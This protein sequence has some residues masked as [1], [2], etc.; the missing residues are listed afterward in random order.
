M[1]NGSYRRRKEEGL[2]STET[3]LLGGPPSQENVQL[4]SKNREPGFISWGVALPC[5]FVGE[6]TT[7]LKMGGN[8]FSTLFLFFPLPPFFFLFFE[9]GCR[10]VIQQRRRTR[11]RI[12]EI[13]ECKYFN[14]FFSFCA[15]FLIP[16]FEGSGLWCYIFTN[17]INMRP[18]LSFTSSERFQCFY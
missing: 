6:T 1:R 15:C 11:S 2:L 5:L 14:F 3:H 16:C 13:H 8:D 17:E 9:I 12:G 7:T 4:S 10:S 18:K